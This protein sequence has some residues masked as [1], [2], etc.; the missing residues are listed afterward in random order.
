MQESVNMYGVIDTVL[1]EKGRQVYVVAPGA[2]V[3][4]AVQEL[5]DHGVGALVVV[6]QRRPIG[7]FSERDVL[8][9]VVGMGRDFESTRVR[10]VMT[11]P[12]VTI[13]PGMRVDEAMALMTEQRIRHL[14]VVDGG[15]L[16]G[17]ISIGDL[18]RRATLVQEEEIK[19]LVGY[20]TGQGA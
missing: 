11:S 16:V 9:R 3:R 10:D 2:S 5:N 14:P 8:R 18:L 19:Q 15:K 6:D 12:P 20:I 1:A 17:M 7:I 4:A 13:H